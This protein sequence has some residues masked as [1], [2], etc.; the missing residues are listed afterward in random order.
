[1]RKTQRAACQGGPKRK[2][3]HNQ[4]PALSKQNLDCKSLNSSGRPD[5][6]GRP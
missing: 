3:S 5:R 2:G 4:R 1:M 6:R